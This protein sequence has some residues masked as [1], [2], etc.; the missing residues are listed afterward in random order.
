MKRV[1][2]LGAAFLLL[3][4][5]MP[6][7]LASNSAGDS[8]SHNG[9]LYSGEHA[10]SGSKMTSKTTNLTSCDQ[11]QVRHRYQLGGSWWTTTATAQPSQ[12]IAIV[13][14]ITAH[15]WSGHRADKSGWS[16]WNSLA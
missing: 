16:S 9:C 6:S 14:G 8:F 12:S 1:A 5:L 11:L 13:D 2:I 10:I 3:V 7:A 15:E 4:A